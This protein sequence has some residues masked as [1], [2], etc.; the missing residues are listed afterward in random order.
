MLFRSYTMAA[1]IIG[2]RSALQAVAESCRLAWRNILP[3][4]VVVTLVVI[5]AVAGSWLG[6]TLG[7]LVPNI[8]Q[9]LEAVVQQI[10]VAYASLV[11]VGEYLKL[12]EPA[13]DAGSQDPAG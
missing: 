6:G 5:V 11:I 2:N 12:R 8:A 1:V 3:T 10:I 7:R 9:F 4:L 13:P